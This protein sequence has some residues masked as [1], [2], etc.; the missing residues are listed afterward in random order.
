MSRKKSDLC[1]APGCDREIQHK[2]AQLCNRCYHWMFY[3]KDR[4]PTEVME[5]KQTLA[6]WAQRINMLMPNVE[7]INARSKKKAG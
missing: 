5:R 2:K 4:T 6:F 3:W 7:V 1:V